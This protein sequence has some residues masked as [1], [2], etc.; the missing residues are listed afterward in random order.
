MIQPPPQYL[1]PGAG[2]NP[3]GSSGGGGPMVSDAAPPARP[4]GGG[5]RRASTGSRPQAQQL[6]SRGRGSPEA[7]VG[8]TRA[9]NPRA[10]T[11][12]RRSPAARSFPS[13]PCAA[14]RARVPSV[15]DR[16]QQLFLG[17]LSA[18]LDDGRRLGPDRGLSSGTYRPGPN[19]SRW[20]TTY[21]DTGRSRYSRSFFAWS[22]VLL[23][24]L[25]DE[26]YR[27][28]VLISGPPAAIRNRPGATG[29]SLAA[30]RLMAAHVR[31]GHVRSS[32][33]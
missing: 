22:S 3:D 23:P 32:P 8:G 11:G 5:V 28:R 27:A 15:P 29:R 14:E 17:P 16:R 7:A 30:R 9:R 10:C 25:P 31:T 12:Q 26:D 6:L 4:D 19:Q 2:P 33:V 13:V 1:D 18:A 21:F 24:L 20:D